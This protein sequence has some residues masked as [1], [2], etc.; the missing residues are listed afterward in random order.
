VS[1]HRRLKRFEIAVNGQTAFL[2]YERTEHALT[3]IHT[4]VPSELRGRH[5]GE[6]LVKAALHAARSEH[7]RVV[8]VC[9]F[10]RAYLRKHPL[11]A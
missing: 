6:S 9:P 4:E 3:L 5:I 8:A 1:D 7:L 2:A 10:V 11:T